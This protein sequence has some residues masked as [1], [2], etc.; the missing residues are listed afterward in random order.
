MSVDFTGFPEELFTFLRELKRNNN[1]EW[2]QDNKSR[3]QECV[4]EPVQSFIT[5]MEPRLALISDSYIADPRANGGSMFRIYRDTRFSKDKTPYK[6]NVGCQFRHTAGKNAHAPGFYLHLEPD[7]VFFGGGV[8]MPPNP[9]LNQIRERIVAKPDEWRSIFQNKSFLR[10]FGELRGDSLKRA[11]R[12]FD[13]EHPLIDDL[14]RKSFIA[15]QE[16]DES[17][18]TS[19]AFIDEVELAFNTTAPMMAF[20]SRSLGLRF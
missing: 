20:I 16:A 11:P 3:Y 17:M 2:F 5:D 9:I 19:E 13:P 10:R 14:K 8:W 15:M 1:R 6:T 18:A 12:G 7:N 4:V